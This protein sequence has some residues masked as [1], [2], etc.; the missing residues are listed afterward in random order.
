MADVATGDGAGGSTVE[1]SF[2]GRWLGRLVAPFE[3]APAER[4]SAPAAALREEA[5]AEAAFL[6]AA[7]PSDGRLDPLLRFASQAAARI[8]GAS[9]AL[10]V[11]NREG[12]VERFASDGADGCT[13]DTLARPEVLSALARHFREGAAAVQLEDLDEP[14]ARLLRAV[15]PRG[16]LALPLGLATDAMLV[17]MEPM[18]G[19]G[20]DREV[21]TAA[22]TLALLA[23]AALDGARRLGSLREACEDL[24]RFVEH[25]LARRDQ[26]LGR[27]ARGLHEGIG[28]WL[29]AANA[30][31]EALEEQLPP[32]G[33]AAARARLHDARVL[34]ERTV[35]E[36][37]DLAQELRPSVLED[38]GY[39]QALRWYVGRLRSRVSAPV[40]LEVEGG[41]TRLPRD[42]EGALF[43]ATEEALAAA[44]GSD[45][46]APVRVRYRRDTQGVRLEILGRS[47]ERLSLVA[48]RERLRPFGGAVH[49]SGE[50]ASLALELPV[51]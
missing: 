50:P 40:S 1:L 39:V 35:R 15:A 13:R 29:A 5:L 33:G 18:N 37:R 38:F 30:Q 24:H 20:F 8:A 47:P 27:T 42:L 7:T 48:I 44:L 26:E 32:S 19:H 41:E 10:V 49:A 22:N 16:F 36:L 21:I 51:A 46:Q 31:L 4:P 14:V 28:Q 3:R 34:L 23:G 25:L 43:R 11:L 12:A 17:V 6:L 2:L 45:S 9:A